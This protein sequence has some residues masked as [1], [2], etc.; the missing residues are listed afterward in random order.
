MFKPGAGF[1]LIVALLMAT[2]SSVALA[3]GNNNATF[4]G[5]LTG[6]YQT[7]NTS[8]VYGQDVHN[9]GNAELYLYGTMNMGAGTWN[10]ELRGSTTPRQNGVS[11]FYGS[12]ALVG[13]TTDGNGK[14]RIAATQLFYQ[15][16]DDNSQLYLGLLDPTG[17]LDGSN[18]A[19]DEYTQFLAG[20][21]V[22]N[23]TIGFPSFVLGTAYQGSASASLGY[24]IFVGSDSG[25]QEGNA[26]YSN[27]FDIDGYRGAY[28][29]GAFTSAELDWHNNGYALKGGIW[30]D[31]GKVGELGSADAT[32]PYGIYAIAEVPAGSGRLQFRAGLA[33]DKA[34]ATANFVSIAYQQPIKLS[35]M[36]TT[37]GVAVGRTGASSERSNADAIVQ[38]E[39]YWRINV[40][41]SFYV[42]P[43]LQYIMNPGFDSSRDNAFI[44]GIR[45]GFEF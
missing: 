13:E 35:N 14:G 27:V 9:E 3:H 23:P 34:Q 29:K 36:N 41:G 33:N 17:L 37:L 45:M 31:T 22:N 21:F 19:N 12:N 1:S 15:I 42:S 26:S 38:V 43:D 40:A 11:S 20:A 24:T 5:S 8:Q 28:H 32:N 2:G 18:V 44:A 16:G 39:A 25:L 4:N 6:T 10:I 30:Y 7:A